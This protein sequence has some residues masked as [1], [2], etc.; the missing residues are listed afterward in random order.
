VAVAHDVVFRGAEILDGSGAE[1]VMGDVAVE[2]E[3]IVAVGD[4]GNAGAVEIDCTDRCLTPGFVDVHTHDDWALLEDPR[5]TFK[6]LQGVTTVVVGNCG[7]SAA[8]RTGGS[9]DIG[10]ITFDS[11]AEYLD[12]IDAARPS[13][14]VAS[15]VGH[16]SI[17][18]AVVGL[19]DPRAASPSE[20]GVMRGLV[21]QAM[22]DG[23]VGLS[24]GLAYEPG[25]Y[26]PTDEI[27]ALAAVVGPTHGLY[28][29]HMRDESDGLVDSVAEAIA[30]GERAG[31][32]VQISH[33]KAAGRPNWGRVADTLTMIDAAR[34]RGVDVMA[35]QYPYTRG[36]TLL[37]QIVRAGALI[38]PSVFGHLTGE[39]ITLAAAPE[40]PAWEGRTIADLARTHDVDAATMA[41]RIVA[42]EGRSCWVII[43]IMSE[44]DVRTV[45]AHPTTMIGSD[46]IPAGRLPHPRLHHT[47]PRVLGRYVRNES[48]LDLPTAIHRM[49]GLPAAR[50]G[51]VDRGGIRPG[52]FA[53]IVVFDRS[54]I[55]D[56]GTYTDPTRVPNGIDGV[57]VNGAAVAANGAHTEA[58]PGHALRAG[59]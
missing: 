36:S 43:D 57:W 45:L 58:R 53:D 31:I 46:G 44:D 22:A 51:L 20:L 52:A 48:V 55:I 59:R 32:R 39:Q 41:D 26:A 9:G 7:W 49:T 24:T 15:L 37:E 33:H 19:R 50:F 21:E 28:A 23:A 12:T 56:T 13:A 29:T 5:L 17:R 18:T 2:A 16:G 54:T 4:I 6:T 3:R 35:D 40:H 38:G 30:I 34:S 27:V 10:G 42:G 8:P 25:R 14:N 11:L 1:P 47:F